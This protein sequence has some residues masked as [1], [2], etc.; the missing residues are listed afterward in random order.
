MVEGFIILIDN[1][2]NHLLYGTREFWNGTG[3]NFRLPYNYID[4]LISPRYFDTSGISWVAKILLYWN[5]F[6]FPKTATK[7]QLSTCEFI[8]RE[9]ERELDKYNIKER[10][11]EREREREVNITLKGRQ[12]V[13]WTNLESVP[14]STIA[15][16][17][18]TILHSVLK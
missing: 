3:R 7:Q 2:I 9:R 10:K 5:N 16:S 15:Q 13:L 14:I 18:K 12:T 4:L 8:E 6:E 1:S 17:Q 11:I